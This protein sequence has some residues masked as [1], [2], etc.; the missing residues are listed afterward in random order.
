MKYA[1]AGHPPILLWRASTRKTVELEENGM[2]L[3]LFGD[4]TYGAI[5]VTMER[6]DRVVLYTDGILEA[7][8]P[9]QELYGADR[10]KA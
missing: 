1:G 8:N 4:A 7:S 5:Q 6:G 10:R 9:S 2:V 3:G